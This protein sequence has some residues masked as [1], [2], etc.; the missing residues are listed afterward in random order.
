MTYLA[1]RL[2]WS[3]VVVWV[4]VS[5]TFAINELLPGDPAR[6]VAGLQARPADVAR[7]REQLGLG[8]PPI[9]RYALF[10]R[11]LVHTGPR[12][13]RRHDPEHGTCAVVFGAGSSALHVDFGKSFQQR[14]PVVDLIAERFPRTFALALAAVA[15]QL[16]LGVA[17]GVAAALWRGSRW[18]RALVGITVLGISL[19]TYLLALALQTLFAR[20]LRLLPLDGYGNSFVQHLRGLVLPALA[21]GLYG[22]AYYTRLVRDEMIGV[23]GRDFIRTARAK[24]ASGARVV[25]AHALRNATLPLLTAVALDFGALLGGAIVTE[26]VFRWPGLG[27]LSVRAALDRDGPVLLA[28]VLVASFAV[29]ATNLIVDLAYARLDPRVTDPRARDNR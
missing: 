22:S 12:Q 2:G 26:T 3:A 9:V 4:V 18:D 25:T 8:R 5:L 27:E 7:I 23:L 28:C 21:L 24:G 20:H 29:V 17:T 6:M 15:F 10:L 16:L 1:R 11:R 19:P 13:V 14:Q